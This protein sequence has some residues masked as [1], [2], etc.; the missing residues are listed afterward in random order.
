MPKIGFGCAAIQSFG[1]NSAAVTKTISE[2]IAAGYRHLDTAAVYNTEANV[3]AA[4]RAS[5]IA[6]KDFF[7]VTKLDTEDMDYEAALRAADKSLKN[8]GL[9]Y[10]DLY[11]VHWPLR[12]KYL[13]A[14]KALEKLYKDGAVKAIGGSNFAV[15]HFEGIAKAGLMKPMSNQ[16][17]LNPYMQQPDLRAFCRE[18]GVAV[19]A[20]SPLGTGNWS[21]AAAE[22]K[23]ISAP[24]IKKLA[25][26]Y[27]KTPAQIILRWMM[28]IGISAVPKSE[29]PARIAENFDVFDFALK[30][31][32]LAAVQK[33]NKNFS[34]ASSFS[35]GPKDLYELV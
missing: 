25:E 10:I 15:R 1:D 33:E 8:L 9:E 30:P 7:I 28:D 3:G 31:E 2:A 16:V 34:I 20:W 18:Q 6:R 13:D 32:D 11:L 23:P 12:D 14:W 22:D 21:A 27:G 24:A 29:K 5:G 17:E 26:Q 35:G 4:V 19:T